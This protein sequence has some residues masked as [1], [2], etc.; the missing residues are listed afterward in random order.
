[1][2][3]IRVL[4]SRDLDLLRRSWVVACEKER[5]RLFDIPPPSYTFVSS[6]SIRYH[7][8]TLKLLPIAFFDIIRQKY[9]N[10]D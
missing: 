8:F 1:L 6:I 2:K 3:G 5:R 4:K 10:A 9:D 7:Q